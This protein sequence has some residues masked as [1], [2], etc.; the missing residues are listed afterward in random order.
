MKEYNHLSYLGFPH[1]DLLIKKMKVQTEMKGSK[2]IISLK[3]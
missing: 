1:Q 2:V 3:S